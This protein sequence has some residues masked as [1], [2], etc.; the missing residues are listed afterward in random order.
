LEHCFQI[1]Q[2]KSGGLL[3]QKTL[4]KINSQHAMHN[5]TLIS[6]VTQAAKHQQ[7][8]LQQQQKQQQIAS[9]TTS[10]EI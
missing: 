6:E 8:L 7:R 1:E 3:T 2:K 10:G 9:T 5:A 4:Q